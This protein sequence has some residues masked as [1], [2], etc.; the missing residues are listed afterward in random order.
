MALTKNKIQSAS[1]AHG[2][3]R[4]IRHRRVRAKIF[5]SASRPRLNVFRSNKYIYLQAIDDGLRKVIFS[6]SD[7]KN[8]S[9]KGKKDKRAD[10]I[11]KTDKAKIAG[12]EFAEK[13]KSLNI[14]EA[15]FDRGGYKY[16]GRVKAAA[17]GAR[18]AGLKF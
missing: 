9:E 6:L 3:R 18:E 11:T 7:A 8:F 16:H 14:F 2:W 12:K 5:G 10:K 17:E 4:K 1:L 13:L 15:V